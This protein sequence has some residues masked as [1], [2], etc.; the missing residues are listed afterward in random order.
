ML[1]KVLSALEDLLDGDDFAGLFVLC[2]E[3]FAI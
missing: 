2:L 1:D 3:D